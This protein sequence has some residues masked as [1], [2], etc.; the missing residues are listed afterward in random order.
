ML[1]RVF[2]TTPLFG[3]IYL[4]M[5]APRDAAFECEQAA[6]A[7]ELVIRM[8]ST[9]R[10]NETP[11]NPEEHP[12]RCRVDVWSGQELT[13]YPNGVDYE[14]RLGGTIIPANRPFLMNR[15]EAPTELT[16]ARHELHAYVLPKGTPT[17][18]PEPSITPE[19][20]PLPETK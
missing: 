14:S 9:S 16:E 11:L 19:E 2:R 6:R 18:E 20:S 5:T 1:A 15:G 17:T 3:Q 10:E 8:L 4:L 13:W 12:A 7:T